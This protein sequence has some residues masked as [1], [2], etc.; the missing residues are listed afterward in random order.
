MQINELTF[1]NSPDLF[2]KM[3][4]QT[5][6]YW[7]SERMVEAIN[8]GT[9]LSDIYELDCGIKTGNNDIFLR[10]WHEVSLEKISYKN[11]SLQEVKDG[12]KKWFKC[13]KGGGY[14][15]W[16]GGAIYV[17]DLEN[18]ASNI[19]RTISK[20]TYRLRNENNYFSKGIMW[21][22]TG[23]VRFSA[24]LIPEGTLIDI[25]TNAIYMKEVDFVLLAYLNSCVNN[26][27]M[28]MINP[29]VSYT[30]DSLGKVKYYN[31]SNNDVVVLS[32]NSVR[33]TKEDWDSFE[34]SWDFKKHPL[35]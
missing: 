35:I 22:L 15:K 8:K 26:N 9:E 13:N 5:I 25:A 12:S 23:D 6:A 1:V 28:I 30:I 18:N 3:P 17:I 20:D 14:A 2:R 27:F 33:T 34:T 32:Q 10:F 7:C 21:T 31:C 16:Y 19:K 24:R 29:T 4:G 11:T